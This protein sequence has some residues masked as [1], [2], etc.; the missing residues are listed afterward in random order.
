MNF[1]RHRVMVATRSWPA[2][3]SA[4]RLGDVSAGCEF[5]LGQSQGHA[6]F[7]DCLADQERPAGFGVP[8]AVLVAVTGNTVNG[9]TRR[10]GASQ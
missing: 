10:P 1:R 5:D 3:R 9:V 8:L 2:Q 6:A 4:G 7:A